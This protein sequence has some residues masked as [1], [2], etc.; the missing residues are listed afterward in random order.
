MLNEHSP[1]FINCESLAIAA[2]TRRLTRLPIDAD[3]ASMT[4]AQ[5]IKHSPYCYRYSTLI[6]R[7]TKPAQLLLIDRLRAFTITTWLTQLLNNPDADP[8]LIAK[9]IS[10]ENNR[11]KTL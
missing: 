6:A 4:I 7:L 5:L 8:E 9:Y 10:I 11:D 1:A 3:I 2:I